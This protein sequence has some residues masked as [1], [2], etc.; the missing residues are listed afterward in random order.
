MTSFNPSS[1]ASSAA[2]AGTS[3]LSTTT[4]HT[5]RRWV[6]RDTPL[7]F[8]WGGLWPL[9]ALLLLT[10]FALGPLA[11]GRIEKSVLNEVRD[12]L[13]EQNH[14]WAR[15]SVSGQNVSL[16]GVPPSIS[17]GDEAM[18]VAR[19]A[20]CPTWA[21]HL[22]CAVKVTGQFDAPVPAPPTPA[23][24]LT[25]AAESLLPPTVTAAAPTTASPQAC[26]RAM[27]DAVAK[28]RIEFATNRADIAASSSTTLDALAQAA[29]ACIGVIEVQGHTDSVGAP[30]R[31]QKLSNARAEAVRMALIARGLPEARLTARG[32]GEEKPVADN[33]SAE[34]RALNRRIEFRVKTAS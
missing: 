32:Y 23:M 20:T 17:A 30:E 13:D 31:N 12:T 29:K 21:G 16:S 2:H 3:V 10:I 4:T 27:A 14:R 9:L 18:S 19:A 22:T 8:L 15:L 25:P 1:V 34:G 11:K 33:D 5:E 24:P 26:E 7:P 6:R 28:S